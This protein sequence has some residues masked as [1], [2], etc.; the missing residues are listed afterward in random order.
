M[1]IAQAP[2]GRRPGHPG[3]C[4]TAKALQTMVDNRPRKTTRRRGKRLADD[5]AVRARWNRVNKLNR[6]GITEEQYQDLLEAQGR[7]CAMCREPFGDTRDTFPQIDHDHNCCE[8]DPSGR[9][10]SCGECIRGLLCFRCNTAL[11]YIE[12]YGALAKAYLDRAPVQ[13]VVRIDQAI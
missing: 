7:A 12:K 8:P 4:I 5:P 9:A 10:R 11:G 6:L 1:P 3:K 2:C 13:V